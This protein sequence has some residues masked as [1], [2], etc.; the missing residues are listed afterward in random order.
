MPDGS[1][2]AIRAERLPQQLDDKITEVIFEWHEASGRVTADEILKAVPTMFPETHA[3]GVPGVSK[4]D[5]R[6]WINKGEPTLT[7]SGWV[8]LCDIIARKNVKDL[9][10]ISK[11]CHKMAACDI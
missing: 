9:G 2:Q 3:T 8:A 4:F 5:V 6:D 10:I 7:Q 11:L 1:W